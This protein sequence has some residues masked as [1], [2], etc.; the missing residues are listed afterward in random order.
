ME[1]NIIV[2][3]GEK[4]SG[5]VQEGIVNVYGGEIDLVINK[6]V[7]LF[8][9][10]CEK[11]SVI[12]NPGSTM[13][14]SKGHVKVYE[15]GGLLL[16]EREY[17]ECE[18]TFDSFL[19][20]EKRPDVTFKTKR[21]IADITFSRNYSV[22]NFWQQLLDPSTRKAVDCIF[23]FTSDVAP[24]RY[25]TVYMEKIKGSLISGDNIIANIVKNVRV[26]EC[27][28][29]T[30]KEATD[31]AVDGGSVLNVTEVCN[32]IELER[33]GLL[34]LHPETVSD[35]MS[36]HNFRNGSLRIHE[37]S[38]LKPQKSIFNLFNNKPNVSASMPAFFT[39][40]MTRVQER[41][42][43]KLPKDTPKRYL[44]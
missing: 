27:S 39:N 36:R 17:K 25:G 3:A 38:T 9:H 10:D 37:N 16:T 4:Y 19:Q 33:Q 28:S 12:L 13:I 26:I 1:N 14:Y 32:S 2:Q 23:R 41:E 18:L 11:G 44:Y 21:E 5:N 34:I 8:L 20:S 7:Q 22:E 40:G 30:C 42:I 43:S 6:G 35:V 29:L 15:S 31:V 24:I